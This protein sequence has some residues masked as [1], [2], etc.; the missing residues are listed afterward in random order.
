MKVVGSNEQV[1]EEIEGVMEGEEG[2]EVLYACM[3]PVQLIPIHRQ[4]TMM[5]ATTLPSSMS[6]Q[7]ST[8]V[9]QPSS[10]ELQPLS[11]VLHPSMVLQPPT[12]LWLPRV[13]RLLTMVSCPL[14]T[15]SEPAR[16]CPG[17][18]CCMGMNMKVH[19]MRNKDQVPWEKP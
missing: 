13:S 3:H 10:M 6:P 17:D 7:P 15:A 14:S 12:V 9:L 2:T 4:L 11:K 8:M 18:T 1:T 19:E 5:P 16:P